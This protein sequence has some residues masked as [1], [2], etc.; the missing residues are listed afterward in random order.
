MEIGKERVDIGYVLAVISSKLIRIGMVC[1]A[2]GALVAMYTLVQQ[3]QYRSTAALVIREPELSFAGE[4]AP[5]STEMLQ[6]LIE[7]T[8]MKSFVYHQLRGDHTLDPDMSFEDFQKMVYTTT[9]RR[10]GVNPDLL[11]MIR[12]TAQS[13]S[14][15]RAARIANVWADAVTTK[16]RQ[17]YASGVDELREFI[18]G[19]SQQA[20]TALSKIE[21]SYTSTLLAT[22]MA[23]RKAVLAQDLMRYEE[24]YGGY[25]ALAAE[26]QETEDL[27]EEV[28]Q[29]IARQEVDGVWI[30]ESEVQD[31]GPQTGLTTTG[32]ESV[33]I[34]SGL[35][36]DFA[37]EGQL[38][39]IIKALRHNEEDL[40]EFESRSELQY[41]Q[42]LLRTREQQLAQIAKE[43]INTQNQL[44]QSKARVAKL[45]EKLSGISEKIVLRKA[46]S[47]DVLAEM[48]LHENPKLAG[49]EELPFIRD[50]V[51]NP[52]YEALKQEV[53]M[54]SAEIEGLKSQVE[55]Y[56]K[57]QE[58]LRQEVSELAQ[59][60]SRYESRKETLRSVIAKDK[61]MLVFFAGQY[62]KA[63]QLRES[64]AKQI[65]ETR[66]KMFARRA[67]LERLESEIDR[68][69]SQTLLADDR[70]NALRRNVQSRR[71]VRTSLAS[72]AEEVT[73]LGVTAQE[74]SRSGA[75]VLYYAQPDFEKVAP[76]RIKV[77]FLCVIFTFAFLVL[78]AAAG[79]VLVEGKRI[80]SNRDV[81]DSSGV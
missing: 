39:R 70:L 22:H 3:N 56:Q 17:M 34:R 18:R 64:L 40:A 62:N 27:L 25:L 9:D 41:R 2:V 51:S 74:A 30:G 23:V 76:H 73:L 54:L 75:T 77:T 63:R 66:A 1:L 19:I 69:Q 45:Q 68:L 20:E 60:I 78:L 31:L 6:A 44:V 11:P 7:S 5:L 28:E 81:L 58:L 24:Q 32:M 35:S 8:E 37:P 42:M 4:G 12:L 38:I 46:L 59:D 79:G 49:S 43:T 61:K 14:P 36:A 13:E 65:Q 50:E 71:Q 26:A 16:T 48:A 57:G 21:D 15:E 80:Q 52:V 10:Q 33:R 67:E 47:N 29:R 53:V 55:Y 72:K